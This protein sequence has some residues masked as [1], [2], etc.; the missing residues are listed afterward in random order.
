[1]LP[2]RSPP[3]RH[4]LA[5]SGGGSGWGSGLKTVTV[6]SGLITL[7]GQVGTGISQYASASSAVRF[8]LSVGQFV[9]SLNRNTFASLTCPLSNNC[10]N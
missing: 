3:A 10:S 8:G 6:P 7:I 2:G 1:M 5:Y 9:A 4:P